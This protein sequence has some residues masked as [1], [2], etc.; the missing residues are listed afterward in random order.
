M[1]HT[2]HTKRYR[3]R[4]TRAHIWPRR[5]TKARRARPALVNGFRERL[6]RS[7][8]VAFSALWWPFRGVLSGLSRR[9]R[10]AFAVLSL[11]FCHVFAVLSPCFRRAFAELSRGAFARCF[12]A[13]L[14][15]FRDA[16]AIL[17][18]CDSRRFRVD[19]ASL[20]RVARTV[21]TQHGTHDFK[22]LLS[23]VYTLDVPGYLPGY[24]HQ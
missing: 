23:R 22:G 6:S 11:R 24:Q 3:T 7:F 10:G 12:V 5:T 19:S 17:S 14:R 4:N 18:L 8:H 13:L 1:Q 20:P 9:V 15:S 16:F 21:S 2:A